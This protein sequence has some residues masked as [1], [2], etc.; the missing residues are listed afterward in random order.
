M[1]INSMFR[2]NEMTQ[3]H[4]VFQQG[5]INENTNFTRI[6]VNNGSENKIIAGIQL[7][8]QSGAAVDFGKSVKGEW[9]SAKMNKTAIEVNGVTY[10]MRG[11]TQG[12]ANTN[13]IWLFG[14]GNTYGMENIDIA[15]FETIDGEQRHNLV[16]FVRQGANYFLDTET[17]ELTAG[18][19]TIQLTDKN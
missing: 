7:N 14:R 13:P 17:C 10:P 16:P 9:L 15:F 18:E 6:I 8:A 4:P 1:Q 5:Y 12:T 2:M 3:Y 19:F 11:T